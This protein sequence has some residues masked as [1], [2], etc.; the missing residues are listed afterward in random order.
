MPQ[1]SSA[2]V[3]EAIPKF[4]AARVLQGLEP[5]F[6]MANLVN[7]DYDDVIANYGDTVD[8]P[9][10]PDLVANNIIETGSLQLQNPDLGNAQVVLDSHVE[11]SVQIPDITRALAQPDLMGIYVDRAVTAIG[12]RVESDLLNQYAL[13]TSNAPVGGQSAMDES[14]IDSAET[15][16]FNAYIPITQQK[17]L[18]VSGNAFG[19]M[20]QIPRLTE[21]QTGVNRDQQS[22]IQTGGLAGKVKD[23]LVY[24]SQLVPNVA[25]TT[26]NLA[27]ARD[28]LSLVVRK[29]APPM[30]GTG[31]IGAYASKGGFGVRVIVSYVHGQLGNLFSVDC[32]YGV[33]VLRQSFGVLVQSN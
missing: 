21:Y 33:G 25:G 13:F 4:I 16:L 6:V 23:F 30:A 10:P 9:I 7:R 31:A 5:I 32:L 20:R 3:A 18:V 2:N 1:L 8:I 24:R 28:A 19:Q 14:R 12:T 15:K 26:Y 27:F 17:Y 22:P 29:L 11:A